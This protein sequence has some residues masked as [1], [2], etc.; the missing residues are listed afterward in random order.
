MADEKEQGT[1]PAAPEPATIADGLQAAIDGGEN[2]QIVRS[3]A[4]HP[5]WSAFPLRLEDDLVLVRSLQDF[6]VNGFAV[7][8]LQDIT[9]VRST[10]AERFFASVLRAEGELDRAPA[11]KPVPLRS[12]RSVL[13][14]VRLHYRHAII[15]CESADGLGFYLGELAGVDGDDATLRYIQVNGT[16]ETALT[17]VPMDDITLVRFDERYVN[18]FGRYALGEDHH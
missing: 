1:G 12:W 10:D 14:A 17:R 4:A 6:T 5:A 7:M 18:L 9:Q 13:E 2:V 11:A 8:R 3:S 15:E 16:R